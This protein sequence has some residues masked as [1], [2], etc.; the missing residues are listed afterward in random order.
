[1]NLRV[2]HA[3]DFVALYAIEEA[4]FEPIFRFPRRYMRQLVTRS[5]AAT[6]IAEVDGIMAGFAAVGWSTRGGTTVAYIETIEV[7]AAYRRQRI[8]DALLTCIE[9]SA[10]EAQAAVIWL[11][12]DAD[13]SSAIRLYEAHGYLQAG[14][15]ENFY[16]QGRAALIYQKP[17][18]DACCLA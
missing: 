4:C 6:W 18:A 2:Y 5:D 16:P 17:L 15:E 9:K 10:V 12:V 1:M 14:R 3:D 7:L 8:G 13:N 11:H